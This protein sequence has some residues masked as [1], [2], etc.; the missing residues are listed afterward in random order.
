[1]TWLKTRLNISDREKATL[2]IAIL[3]LVVATI[4]RV[5]PHTPNVTPFFAVS[6]LV[7]FILGRDRA[8]L[9]GLLSAAAMVVSDLAL[10]L[11]ESMLFVYAGMAMAALVGAY[12]SSFV[13]VRGQG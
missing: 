2:P 12:G 13:S 3:L 10:G 6:I 1:M 8:V 5:Q 9:A 4:L 11:H 7:G